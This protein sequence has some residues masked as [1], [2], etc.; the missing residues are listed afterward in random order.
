MAKLTINHASNQA[1]SINTIQSLINMV[2][3]GMI[4]EEEEEEEE[5]VTPTEKKE[6]VV[7]AKP[8]QTFE[9]ILKKPIGC[10]L[11]ILNSN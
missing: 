8:S 5:Q 9:P 3:N 10:F 7:Q 6:P 11:A 1:M 4:N 2:I